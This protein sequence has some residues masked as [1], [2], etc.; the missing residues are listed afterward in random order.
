[1]CVNA[2]SGNPDAEITDWNTLYDTVN[3]KDDPDVKDWNDN[4]ENTN[5]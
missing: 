4:Y 1:M 3:S 2:E 5:N